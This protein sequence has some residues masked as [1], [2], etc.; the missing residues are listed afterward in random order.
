MAGPPVLVACIEG[1]AGV[2]PLHELREVRPR[3]ADQ[4]VEMVFHQHERVE[5]DCGRGDV[6]LEL[7]EKATPVSIGEE[8]PRPPVA[9]SGD[10]VERVGKVDPWRSCHTASIPPDDI[11]VNLIFKA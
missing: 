5:Q 9:A 2:Q 1:I 3:R 6:V 11:A 7:T 8:N 10:M 4:E